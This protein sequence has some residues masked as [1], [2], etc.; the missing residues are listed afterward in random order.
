M[1]LFWVFLMIVGSLIALPPALALIIV[2][3]SHIGAEKY[4]LAVRYVEVGTAIVVGAFISL[5][6]GSI[7]I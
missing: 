3:R 2:D 5:L 4:N 6:I 1:M 7:V